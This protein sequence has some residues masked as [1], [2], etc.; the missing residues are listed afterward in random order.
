MKNSTLVQYNK[1][2]ERAKA[3]VIK[4]EKEL[5]V[6]KDELDNI[7]KE[8]DNLLKDNIWDLMQI[9]GKSY[10]DVVRYINYGTRG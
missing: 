8:R 1:R 3:K 4:A 5:K 9:R 2:I 10:A 6:A 7:T